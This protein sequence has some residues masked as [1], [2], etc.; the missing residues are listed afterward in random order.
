MTYFA[1][2]LNESV[3]KSI[4]TGVQTTPLIKQ[5][6]HKSTR[7]QNHFFLGLHFEK[8]QKWPEIQIEKKTLEIEVLTNKDAKM[9]AQCYPTCL[10]L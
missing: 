6:N 1:S 4:E 3:L 8:R 2:K 5:N 9:R 10:R 7:L